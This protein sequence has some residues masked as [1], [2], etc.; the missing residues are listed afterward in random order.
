M[1][2]S[3]SPSM[4]KRS[5]LRSLT[6]AVVLTTSVVVGGIA[7]L[8]VFAIAICA[9]ADT[10]HPTTL[11]SLDPTGWSGVIRR[12]RLDYLVAPIEGRERF[13]VFQHAYRPNESDVDLVFTPSSASDVLVVYRYNWHMSGWYC[14]MLIRPN[15]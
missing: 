15:G 8:R 12:A 6:L 1:P 11:S 9:A 13:L 2:F 4:T 10:W 7:F 14:K 5:F 3:P